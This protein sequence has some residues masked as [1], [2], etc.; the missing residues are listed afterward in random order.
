MKRLHIFGLGIAAAATLSFSQLHIHELCQGF[1]PENDMKISVSVQNENGGGLNE[2]EFNK[3]LDRIE[4]VYAPLIAAE[5]GRLR[6]SRQ[7]NNDTVNASAQRQGSTYIVNMYGGLARHSE[8]TADGF[9]LVACHE[10]GHHMGGA[11]KTGWFSTWASNEGQSDYFAG[12]QCLRRVWTAEDNA[13]FAETHELD[14]FLV[15]KCRE[16]WS[17]QEEINLCARIGTAGMSVTALFRD[18][19]QETQDPQFNTPDRRRVSRTDNAHPA[20]QCRLDT[21]FQGGLCTKRFD[22]S[23]SNNDVARG[24]CVESDGFTLGTRPRCWYGE[25][26]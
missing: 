16:A 9:S 24:T 14:P 19:R 8:I 6:I 17:T 20:T 15:S 3:V 22:E 1:L 26:P 2:A 13:R 4:E 5:G 7:W 23:L 18:L 25:T 10:V 11:P 12:L 21:Y